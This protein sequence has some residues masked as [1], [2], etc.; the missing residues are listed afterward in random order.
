MIAV[1]LGIGDGV[2][3]VETTTPST[4]PLPNQWQ[5]SNPGGGGA[6]AAVGAGPTGIILAASD[7]SGAY[8]SLDD[9]QT[10]DVIGSERGLPVTHIAS[11][12]FDTSDGNILYLGTESGL[13]RSINA[14]ASMQNVLADGYIEAISFA[15]DDPQIG[16]VA[17]HLDG[18]TP[19]GF[20]YKTADRGLTWSQV[21]GATLPNGLRILK[22]VVDPTD[23]DFV[24]LLAGEG[25]F[26]C[27]AAV[28]Y[29][30]I[31]GGTT[32]SQLANGLGQ[33]MDIALD[34]HDSDQLYLTTYG[35][36]WDV[37]YDCISDD[38]SG[39]YLYRGDFNGSWTWTQITNNS[40]LTQLNAM[41]WL[42]ADSNALRLISIDYPELFESTD[43]GTTWTKIG[44]KGDWDGGWAQNLTYG[45]SYNGDA[46]TLG[47]SLQ[48]ADT[49]LWI[50]S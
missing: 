33:I 23:A 39:G 9:G 37:G 50:D 5:P 44:D 35:D 2:V 21:S 15:S 38:A 30:S 34:P 13:Y 31:D 41:L 10:W 3:S 1:V 27:G 28:V 48:D 49:L 12:G 6:F 8:R 14:G 4:D 32:W 42:D 20:I 11:V 36:V 22:V 18:D 24:Y 47:L 26:A 43:A 29:Q 16:Y 40:N 25:R 19:D 17:Y 46:K 7:L 45:G